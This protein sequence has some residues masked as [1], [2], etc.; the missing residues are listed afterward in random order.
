MV[1]SKPRRALIS[2]LAIVGVLSQSPVLAV[3]FGQV[4][5]EARMSDPQYAAARAER[6]AADGLVTQARGQLLPQLSASW[7]RIN[8]ET[9]NTVPGLRGPRTTE[10]DFVA[11]NTSLNLSMALLRP[12]IWASYAQSKAQVRVAEGNFRQAEQDLIVRVSQAYFEVLLAEDNLVLAREQKAAITEQ[13]KQAKRYF[14]A[15]VGTVTDINEVQA[16][17]DTITAQQLAAEN[18]LE[19]RIRSLEQLVGKVYRDLARPGSLPLEQPDPADVDAWLEFAYANNPL[20][21]AREAALDVATQ[22]HYKGYAGH[23][24]T[25]DLVASRGRAQ[26]P[27]YTLIDN[28]NWNTSIGLQVAIPLFSGGTTQGRVNQAASLREKAQFDVESARRGVA[29]S[30]RQ[31][32]LNVVNGIAQVR[33][34]EQAVKSNELA[35]YSAR[36]GQEAGTRTSFDVLNAQQLLFSAKRDLAQERYRYILSRLKLR[37]ATGLLDD[38]DVIMVDRMTNNQAP[39][40]KP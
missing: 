29:L 13:L 22:E 16:R 15:G 14:E 3:G 25:L 40:E 17:F 31:E 27:S 33:A 35:L 8:N 1:F 2:T 9:D 24:P 12:Q 38:Q 20:L 32:Y 28:T 19:V 23:L 18:T 4:Y 5:L 6:N 39:T 30:T 10:Y 34:L 7:S 11:K 21:K 26:D 37:A 36:K